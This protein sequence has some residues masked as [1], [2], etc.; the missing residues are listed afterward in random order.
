MQY[1]KAKRIADKIV[2]LLS[3]DCDIIHI[4]GSI[5]RKKPDVKDIEIVCLPKKIP[6]D[7]DL[8]GGAGDYR[9]GADFPHTISV[10]S[11]EIVKGHVNGRYMQIRLKG[12]SPTSAIML[13]LFMPQPDDYYRQLAIRTG[14]ADYSAAVL[15]TAWRKNG[16]VGTAQG[17]RRMDDCEKSTSGWKIV[18]EKGDRPP[19]WK[20]EEEFFKWLGIEYTAPE[21]RN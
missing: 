20:S 13:D 18:N 10:I 8:F 7:T 6:T 9:V 21:N 5:R 4:A 2:R 16:W 1:L 19:V 15:A 3:P 14:S 11:A 17:L 12:S